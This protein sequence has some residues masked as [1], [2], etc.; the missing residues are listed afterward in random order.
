MTRIVTRIAKQK[1]RPNRRNVYLDGAFAFGCNLNVVAK[2]RLCEG[3]TLSEEQVRQIQ[4]GEVKQ[5]CFDWAIKHL[6]SRLHSRAELRKKLMRREYGDAVVDATLEDLARLGYV[7]DERFAKTKA[8]S[9]AQHKH[10]GRRRAFVELMKSGVKGDVA[11][12]ALTDVYSAHDSTAVAR[13]LAQKQLPRLKKL[14]PVVARRRLV[15][16][17]QRRGFDY[18]SIKPVVDEV[19]GRGAERDDFHS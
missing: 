3:M 6:T 2:F 11:D 19:L 9:A 10:H 14:D 13:Q 15:G 8:L 4:L 17:L 5:E 12:K 18:D 16:M 7:D 1:R